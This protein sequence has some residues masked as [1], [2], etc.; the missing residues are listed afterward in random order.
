VRAPAT[1]VTLALECSS[2]ASARSRPWARGGSN[3]ASDAVE[4]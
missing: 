2:D 4:H 1:L 3:L